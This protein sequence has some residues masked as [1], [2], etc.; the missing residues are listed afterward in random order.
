[1]VGYKANGYYAR[2]QEV[3]AEHRH[4][5]EVGKVWNVCAIEQMK[6]GRIELT[7]YVEELR[8]KEEGEDEED[9]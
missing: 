6:G 2:V 9:E 4:S 7:H 1:M 5:V 8:A 3:E